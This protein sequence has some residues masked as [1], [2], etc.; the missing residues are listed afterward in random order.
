M[1]P[2]MRIVHVVQCLGMGGQERLILNLSRE[3]ARRGHIPSVIS[4]TPGG[5]IRGEFEGIEVVD[6]TRREG[7]DALVI[8][9][10]ARTLQKL[11]P[12][13]V[14]T[15]NPS[16]MFYAVPAAHLVRVKRTVH[17]KHGKNIYGPK[18]LMAARVVVRT[19]SALVCVSE[20]TA[21][22]ARTKEKV[23]EKKL[24]VIPNGI[25]LESFH[26]DAAARARIRSDLGIP[27]EAIVFGTVGRLAP[28]KDYPL[29]VRATAP[30]LGEDARL[31]IVGGGSHR[32]AIEAA[33]P[34]D[35]K[36]YVTLTGARRDV[37]AL[38]AAMDVF[39]LTSETEGL[40][41][42]IPEAMASGLPIVATAVG[43]LPSIV[44]AEVGTLVPYPDQEGL[45]RAF[46]DL[47]SNR[48]KL[49]K[50]AEAARAL[51]LARFSIETMTD[52]YLELYAG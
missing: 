49:Q 32:E 13:V 16:P 33:I 52:R 20:G 3:L 47:R 17:T 9:R 26:P 10:M 18:G 35:K 5:E 15:H 8:A 45:T 22:V 21:D 1:S 46:A 4:L 30:L 34:A 42:V 43:G 48:G 6:V 29:L 25:P 11:R 23:P 14:H 44:P 27:A 7:I 28:E 24:H 31:V 12:D 50:M 37:P 36:K 41:L 2:A 51:A 19:L 40:P 38:L 39:S